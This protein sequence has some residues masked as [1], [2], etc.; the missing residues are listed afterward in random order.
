MSTNG[1]LV[2]QRNLESSGPADLSE[3]EPI[4]L[5]REQ[6]EL[7]LALM[8]NPPPRNPKFLEAQAW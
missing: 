1:N 6:P 5:T 2:K 3:T 8:V 4:E 7:L